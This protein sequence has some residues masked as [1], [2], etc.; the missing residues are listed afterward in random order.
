M[1]GDVSKVLRGFPGD[2]PCPGVNEGFL[3]KVV[4]EGKAE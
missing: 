1:I 4:S 2:I 3:E